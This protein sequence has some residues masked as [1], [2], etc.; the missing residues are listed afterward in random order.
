MKLISCYIENF[1][2]LHEIEF[3]FSDGLSCICEENGYGKSTL[4]A[5]ISAVFYGLPDGR[6]KASDNPRKKYLPWQG[7]VFGGSAVIETPKGHFRVGRTFG[8]KQTEDTF[9]LTD[10]DT[11]LES[12][13]YGEKIGEE[14]F[15]LTEESFMKSTYLPQEAVMTSMTPDINA[16]LTNLLESSD[17]MSDYGKAV[18]RLDS[19]IKNLCNAQKH[20]VI[21]ALRSDLTSCMLEIEKCEARSND[22]TEGRLRLSSVVSE[23]DACT[24]RLKE[25]ESALR[26]AEAD[27]L[28]AKDADYCRRLFE[29]SRAAK[30]RADA[31][32]RLFPAG[33]P[34]DGEIR[35]A[36]GDA[37]RYDSLEE[38]RTG[39]SEVEKKRLAGLR[40]RFGVTPDIG[41]ADRLSGKTSELAAKA[42]GL[43]FIRAGLPSEPRKPQKR[44]NAAGTVI[45]CAGLALLTFGIILCAVASVAAGAVLC[46][47]GS[48]G[49]FA[50][51]IMLALGNSAK[52]RDAEEYEIKLAAYRAARD[53]LSKKRAAYE[54]EESALDLELSSLVPEYRRGSERYAAI[55]EVRRGISEYMS[56][57]SD[58]KRASEAE[59]RRQRDISEVKGRLD[60]FFDRYPCDLT[61]GYGVGLDRLRGY[62]S[63][64]EGARR[65]ASEKEKAAEAF[66][67]E[68]EIDPSLP[69][70]EM[71]DTAA[72]SDEK[73]SL[74][75][76]ISFLEHEKGRL[77]E[78]IRSADA[79]SEALPELNEKADALRDRI[80]LCER[81]FED[82]KAAKELLAKAK[83]SLSGRYLV[84]MEKA[85]DGSFRSVTGLGIGSEID[86]SLALKL[87][88]KK[89]RSEESYSRGLRAIA[90]VCLRIA[91]TD[92]I[93]TDDKPF[94]LLD[95]PFC[96]LDDRR[97]ANA[98]SMLGRLAGGRQIIYLTCH[99]SRM[100]EKASS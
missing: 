98:L 15:G 87:G 50:G 3:D 48:L 88:D 86:T 75:K 39:L 80:R 30:E 2:C 78:A 8:K 36:S 99:S 51:G 45:L 22:A 10:L 14:L 53:D 72:L 58:E 43:D 55:S 60:A 11:R 26:K 23:L 65:D 70:P 100:P 91:L 76:R 5:F 52:K 62:L 93:F 7:G 32:A 64:L 54:A 77:T 20:G 47:L 66:A 38:S 34:T 49:A 40:E 18:S 85:F 92:A 94:L 6:R 63:T 41:L 68:K 57:L 31:L 71:P 97:L 35:E 69:L 12:L 79:G 81:D 42:E 44:G 59:S 33:I 46:I 83:D 28:A 9:S 96:D 73:V 13:A 82:A 19:Y 29:A 74:G 37:A 16:R 95:D 24:S 84:G 90:A 89:M 21:P 17:D 67:A 61:G 56:L 1:G 25:I 27:S 4:A